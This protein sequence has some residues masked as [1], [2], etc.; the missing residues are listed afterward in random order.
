MPEI[1]ADEVLVRVK[2]CGICGSDIAYYFGK[3]SSNPQRQGPLILGHEYTG[4]VV[5]VGASPPS[6]SSPATAWCSTPCNTA[7][8]ATCASAARPTCARTRP[9]SASRATAASPNT[10]SASTPAFIPCPTTCRTKTA[11]L[12]EPLA[13]ATYG[14]KNL[15]I[16]PG[17][18]CVV[19]GPGAIGCMMIE[20]AEKLGACG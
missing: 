15:A 11:A 4:E 10:R 6:S 3:A 9:S 12:T 20:L 1:A 14:L 19:I 8:P 5:E 18:F 17:N 16:E 7:T 2:A 13:C